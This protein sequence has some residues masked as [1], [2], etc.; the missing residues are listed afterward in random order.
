[1]HDADSS[2]LFP[3]ASQC[4][5]SWRFEG[6]RGNFLPVRF[7]GIHVNRAPLAC[8]SPLESQKRLQQPWPEKHLQKIKSPQPPI[9]VSVHINQFSTHEHLTFNAAEGSWATNFATIDQWQWTASAA[10]NPTHIHNT[11]NLLMGPLALGIQQTNS[12]MYQSW[13]APL[14]HLGYEH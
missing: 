12:N 9:T 14:Q 2:S 7:A 10:T 4:H 6:H 13:L 3:C 8:L 5:H 1:M 11:H